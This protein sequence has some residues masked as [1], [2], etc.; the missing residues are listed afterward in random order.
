MKDEDI[1]NMMNIIDK[2]DDGKIS[3]TE[4]RVMLGAVP[5]LHV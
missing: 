5:L 1:T 3:F 4:F 2:N